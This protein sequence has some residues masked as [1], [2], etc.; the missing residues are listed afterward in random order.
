MATLKQLREHHGITQSVLANELHTSIPIISNYET[1][2]SLPIFEDMTILEHQFQQGIDW[3]EKVSYQNKKVI[4]N[5]IV[6]L[7]EFYPINTVLNFIS[8]SIREDLKSGDDLRLIKH[9]HACAM[10]YREPPMFI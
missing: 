9:F 4:I 10:R 8:K 5:A 7:Q 1:G 2:T 3:T 6:T